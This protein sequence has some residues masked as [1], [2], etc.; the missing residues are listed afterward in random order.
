M[1]QGD[2]LLGDLQNGTVKRL[3][4][5]LVRANAC[6]ETGDLFTKLRCL[7][8]GVPGSSECRHDIGVGEVFVQVARLRVPLMN[9]ESG[10]SLG[11]LGK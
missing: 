11:Q 4:G 2:P 5:V 9:S 8:G 10:F 3:H 1:Y 7:L 6:L